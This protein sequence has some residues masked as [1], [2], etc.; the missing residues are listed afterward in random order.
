MRENY[1]I[2]M[3]EYH[4]LGLN[5]YAS[6]VWLRFKRE[7]KPDDIA[8][9]KTQVSNWSGAQVT[10]NVWIYNKATNK[11][12]VEGEILYTLVSIKS[13]RPVRISEEIKERHKI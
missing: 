7:L 8:L 13:G 12:A 5:W 11:T 4:L 9:V 10:I 2:P 6:E 3:E 1:K